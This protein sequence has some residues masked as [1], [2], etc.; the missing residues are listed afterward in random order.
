[1][2]HPYATLSGAALWHGDALATLAALPAGCAQ[3]AITSPP[4]YALR[5]YG[6]E[7]QIGLE[8]TP[9]EYV[10]RLVEVFRAVRRV[11]S[12]D[13]V[14]WINCGDSY[15]AS[16]Y[17][18]HAGT[19]GA[20][21]DEGGKQKHTHGTGLPPKN[22]LGMP[23]RLAF[24]LQED[25]WILRSEVIWAKPNPMPE[26][27][28]DRPTKSHE[29]LFMLAKRGAYYWDAEAV[30]EESSPLT[31]CPK[32]RS[33]GPKTLANGEAFNVRSD[34]GWDAA[35]P[36]RPAHR[37]LRTVWSIPSHSFSDA[38]FATYPPALVEK[39]ILSSTSAAGQCPHCGRA[40][41]RV[42]E[43][44]ASCWE[45]RKEDGAT[46]GADGRRS[47]G[48]YQRAVIQNFSGRELAKWRNEHPDQHV[49]WHPR[50]QCPPHQPVPQIVLDPFSGAATTGLVALTHGRRYVGI[51]LSEAYLKMSVKRLALLQQRMSQRAFDFE[52]P[53]AV[54]EAPAS[55][56]H[57]ALALEMA[58]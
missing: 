12:D 10:S 46:M 2:S 30:K 3:T 7:G 55:E 36:Y 58:V 41:E 40:W 38:H 43:R 11:L 1:V 4:Y 48:R 39:C 6:C 52:E 21:R 35:Q 47:N 54:A 14:L 20:Q 32:A 22:L 50:C 8:K 33:N 29:Q 25:G 16:G 24:A 28:T 27:V 51:E 17:S 56:E 5:D 13:G 31:H 45:Q 57:P 49:G 37:N 53:A 44:A 42:V 34:A 19:N 9:A 15:A 23:W 18:N 26:S